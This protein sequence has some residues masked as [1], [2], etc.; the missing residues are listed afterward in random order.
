MKL[1]RAVGSVILGAFVTIMLI[2]VLTS[3]AFP[4]LRGSATPNSWLIVATMLGACSIPYFA[5]SIV[6]GYLGRRKGWKLAAVVFVPSAVYFLF[7]FLPIS[8]A[9]TVLDTVLTYAM[10]YGLAL[11]LSIFGGMFGQRIF[12]RRQRISPVAPFEVDAKTV[13][14]GTPEP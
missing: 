1:L 5:G 13:D 2:L 8:V 6:A 11:M 14:A 9:E 10:A 4:A 7:T 12:S 3:A